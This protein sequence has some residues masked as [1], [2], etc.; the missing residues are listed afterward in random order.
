[1][2][3]SLRARDPSRMGVTGDAG[4]QPR[5]RAPHRLAASGGRSRLS[6]ALR[7]IPPLATGSPLTALPLRVQATEPGSSSSEKG[8]KTHG[9]EDF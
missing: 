3:F 9:E 6:V 8:I 1:M 2:F 4:G 7:W 5:P